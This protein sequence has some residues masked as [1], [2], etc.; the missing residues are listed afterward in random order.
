MLI[1]IKQIV[2]KTQLRE[3]LTNILTLVKQ[4]KELVVSDRGELV[5]KIIPVEEKDGPGEISSFMT[6]VKRLRRKLSSQN[7][8][9]DSVKVLKEMRRES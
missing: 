2:T 8:S 7:P 6:G 4:G 1:D 5:V 3:D 9:F